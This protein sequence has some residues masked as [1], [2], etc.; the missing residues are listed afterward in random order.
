MPNNSPTLSSSIA[1]SSTLENEVYIYNTSVHFT[2]IDAN[3]TLTYSSSQ[4]D[5]S[6]LPGWLNIHSSTGTLFGAPLDNDVGVMNITITVTDISGASVSDTFALSVTDLVYGT[7]GDDVIDVQ[8]ITGSIQAGEGVDTVVIDG[9]YVDFSLFLENDG[10]VLVLTD[11][12]T[13]SSVYQHEVKL[14]S[15]EKLQFNDV[16]VAVVEVI[17]TGAFQVN[18]FT[19]SYQY[20]SKI[21]TLNDDG[22]VIT[23]VSYIQDTSNTYGIYAQKY[24]ANANPFGAEF[25]VNTYT[26][27]YQ[28]QPSTTAL[29]DGGFVVTWQ[30]I[31]QDGD[32]YGIYAQRYSADGTVNGAEFQ[33]NTKT[34]GSQ[35]D[36]SVAAL[37]DG[38]FVIAWHDDYSTVYSDS[39][40]GGYFQRYD[41]EGNK[42]GGETNISGITHPSVT[43]FSDGGFVFSGGTGAIDCAI[44]TITLGVDAILITI[45][46]I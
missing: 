24:D 43:E 19:N 26:S 9:N 38:G 44:R 45:L 18:T 25:L 32:N 34:S 37:T 4:A 41:A 36:Q 13:D 10:T 2:D 33:V 46:I 40:Y 35:I 6:A 15:V 7:A 1:D 27:G 42:V 30:S 39:H 29:A 8:S 20:N 14:S 31:H 22:F 16:L 23:W 11:K 12:R 21:T 3:D 17:T 28:I 5:G